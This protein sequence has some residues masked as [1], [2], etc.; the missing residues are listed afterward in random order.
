MCYMCLCNCQ[1]TVFDGDPH[2]AKSAI[3]ADWKVKNPGQP[4]YCAAFEEWED[5]SDYFTILASLATV[6]VNIFVKITIRK[7]SYWE[8]PHNKGTVLCKQLHRCLNYGRMLTD[9]L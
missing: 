3:E 4:E 8:K 7:T 1:S 6:F 9:C 5:D 2:C